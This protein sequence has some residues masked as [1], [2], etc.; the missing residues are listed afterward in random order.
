M[1][2]KSEVENEEDQHDIEKIENQFEEDY[3]L[4]IRNKNY[5]PLMIACTSSEID[6]EL[7]KILKQTGF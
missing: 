2:K 3:L 6:Q 7:S 5:K 4:Y 1:K